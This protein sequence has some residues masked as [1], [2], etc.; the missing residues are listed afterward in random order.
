MLDLFLDQIL[1]H[2][3]NDKLDLVLKSKTKEDVIFY[4]ILAF[5]QYLNLTL[6]CVLLC[7]YCVLNILWGQPIK[8]IQDVSTS[9]FHEY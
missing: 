2:L 5:S 3:E 4:I 7:M 6:H 9:K 8:L 1:W